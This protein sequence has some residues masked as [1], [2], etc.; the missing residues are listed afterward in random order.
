VPKF[1]TEE[2]RVKSE[3]KGRIDCFVSRTLGDYG[4]QITK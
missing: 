4:F 1:V 2:G 3:P